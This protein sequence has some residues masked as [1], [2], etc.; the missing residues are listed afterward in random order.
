MLTFILSSF[1]SLGS[2]MKVAILKRESGKY[3]SYIVQNKLEDVVKNL[4]MRI[5][6]QEWDMKSDLTIL[7]D[8]W[9]FRIKLPLKPEEL[10]E[11]QDYLKG[12][13]GKEALADVP[14]Y[15]IVFRNKEGNETVYV[16]APVIRNEQIQVLMEIAEKVSAPSPSQEELEFANSS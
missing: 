6:N 10:E 11:Y 5:V 4:I 13:T 9:E 15:A 12:R 8:V 2:N 1:R 16:I 7:S 3:E 14:I